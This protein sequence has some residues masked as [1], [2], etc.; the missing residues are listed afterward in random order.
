[1]V[2]SSQRAA[3]H[4]SIFLL[5]FFLFTKLSPTA[6]RLFFCCCPPFLRRSSGCR[7]VLGEDEALLLRSDQQ[8]NDTTDPTLL[9]ADHKAADGKQGGGGSQADS[10]KPT[11]GGKS[12][13]K[14]G[15]LRGAGETWMI[16]GP[17]EYT[18]PVEVSILERRQAIPLDENEGIYVSCLWSW[19]GSLPVYLLYG[20][21]TTSWACAVHG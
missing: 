15:K 2:K 17:C 18:P 12:K 4:T 9:S 6:A 20:T 3:L 21:A 11:G 1:M 10:V 7:Y 8:F 5:L 19:Q 13:T 16:Y 14:G